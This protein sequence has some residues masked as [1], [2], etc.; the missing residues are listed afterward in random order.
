MNS[1]FLLNQIR[2]KR[3]FLCIGLDSDLRKIPKH[4]LSEEDPIFSFNKQII[5][6]TKD[7]CVAYKP[8]LA[9][10]ESLGAEGLRTLKKTIDYIPDEIFTIADAKRGDIGN[11]ADMY[12]QAY[13]G[14]FGFDSITLSPYMGKDSIIPFLQHHGKWAIVLGLTSNKGA[15]DIQMMNLVN[16]DKVYVDVIRKVATW[17]TVENTMFVVGAT[18]PEYFQRIRKLI[19]D[20]WLLVPG[21]GA[22]GGNFEQVCQYGI[23]KNVGLLI[24]SSRDILY[25]GQDLDFAEKSAEKAQFLQRSMATVLTARNF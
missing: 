24:N 7:L 15:E 10:Y 8:N 5:D 4:L 14:E 6:A 9:F 3:S 21:I 1:E 11:T 16:S 2:S 20:H 17:G 23:N 25:A 12:A 18:K 13:F 19:P 22:Q